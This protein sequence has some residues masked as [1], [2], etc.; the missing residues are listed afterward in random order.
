MTL[1]DEIG[2]N[3]GAVFVDSGTVSRHARCPINLETFEDPHTLHCQHSFCKHCISEHLRQKRASECPSCRA[4]V[5]PRE[6][7]KNPTLA[8]T[9]A[10]LV[11][12]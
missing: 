9:V 7:K 10:A 11:G 5:Q 4:P 12:N 2:L 1:E 6:V 8:A 3:T